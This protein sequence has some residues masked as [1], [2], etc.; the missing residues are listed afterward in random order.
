VYSNLLVA[1][2]GGTQRN[3]PTTVGYW[4]KIA[5][6]V[7]NSEKKYGFFVTI[8]RQDSSQFL[9]YFYGIAGAASVGLTQ[10]H[11]IKTP[12]K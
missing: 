7:S 11:I 3:I 4:E 1:F 5:K 10:C 12:T 2:E 9:D 8:E 6:V